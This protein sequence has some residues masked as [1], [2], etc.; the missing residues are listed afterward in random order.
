MPVSTLI[1]VTLLGG[2]P[3]GSGC[4]DRCNNNMTKCADPCGSNARCLDK[5][6]RQA[7]SCSDDCNATQN[8]DR[9]AARAKRS[10]LPCGLNE[11]TKQPIP[12][13]DKE[14]QEM[15]ESA[16]DIKGMCKDA[17]GLP[18]GCPGEMDKVKEKLKKMGVE[19]DS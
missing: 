16:K 5:C 3:D 18:V 4:L 19:M 7:Q 6:N 9:N 2:G 14:E 12:C 13:S 1:L 15:R 8:K 11:Q 10:K 17:E